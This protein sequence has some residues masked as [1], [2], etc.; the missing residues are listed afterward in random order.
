[1]PVSKIEGLG[2]HHAIEEPYKRRYT[3]NLITDKTNVSTPTC[4]V[5]T[6]EEGA[7]RGKNIFFFF[8]E[9]FATCSIFYTF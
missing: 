9:T 5:S 6:G 7:V 3:M 4:N 1:M 2:V 8:M